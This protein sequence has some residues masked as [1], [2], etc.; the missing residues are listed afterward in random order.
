V[1]AQGE[2]GVAS[3]RRGHARWVGV[4]RCSHPGPCRIG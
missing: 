3:G 1:G 4:R 2:A